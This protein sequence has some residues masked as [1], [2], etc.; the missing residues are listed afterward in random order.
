M[1]VGFK[2][3]NKNPKFKIVL[4]LFSFPRSVSINFRFFS[5]NTMLISEASDVYSKQ[6]T[7]SFSPSHSLKRKMLQLGKTLI[8]STSNINGLSVSYNT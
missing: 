7:L 8:R 5:P 2:C 4:T 1:K 3:D 6:K